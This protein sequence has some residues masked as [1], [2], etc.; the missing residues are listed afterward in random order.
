MPFCSVVCDGKD[1]THLVFKVL[2]PDLE[3]L[4]PFFWKKSYMLFDY[5]RSR[6]MK[7]FLSQSK[8]K[9]KK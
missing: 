7:K 6:A 9:I 8:K 5:A 2:K 1:R 4:I 3:Q